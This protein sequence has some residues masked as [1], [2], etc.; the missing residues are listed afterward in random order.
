[1][2]FSTPIRRVPAA[3]APLTTLTTIS[4]DITSPIRPNVTR[5]GTHGAIELVSCSLTMSQDS[6]A[7]HRPG[8][9]R[10]A[11]RRDVGVHSAPVPALANR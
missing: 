2:D 3:T 10:G 7:E 5:N 11:H 6:R 4:T 1:M 8:G 9:Q